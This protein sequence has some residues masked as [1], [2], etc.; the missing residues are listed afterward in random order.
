M[1]TLR[2]EAKGADDFFHR[3]LARIVEGGKEFVSSTKALRRSYCHSAGTAVKNSDRTQIQAE[4]RMLGR[5]VVI[6]T[7]VGEGRR[8]VR[9]S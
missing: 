4:W 5:S 7:L 1:R 9:I 2:G 3:V 8:I 6:L